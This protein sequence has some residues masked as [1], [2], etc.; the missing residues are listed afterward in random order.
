MSKDKSVS[1]TRVM[2]VDDHQIFIDGLKSLLQGIENIK[3]SATASSGEEALRKLSE[4]EVDVILMDIGMDGID[5]VETTK[6][7]TKDYSTVKV[8]ALTMFGHGVYIEK[9]LK[10]GARGYV[11][12][13]TTKEELI[14]AIEVVNKGQTYYSAQVAQSLINKMSGDNSILI[15]KLTERELEILKMIAKQHNNKEIAALLM[16][17]QYTVDTHRKNILRK[18]GLKNTAGLIKYAMENNLLDT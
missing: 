9:M 14:N 7:I 8:I 18:L 13:N 10:A 2:I 12:K 11:L 17:S 1:V 4:V 5:G 6:L 16:V 15:I 3:I